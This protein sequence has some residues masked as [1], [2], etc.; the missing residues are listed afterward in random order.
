MR[1]NN[2]SLAQIPSDASNVLQSI[3]FKQCG[4]LKKR[5]DYHTYVQICRQ[6]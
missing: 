4:Q 1:I 5:S 2:K 6:R 3:T